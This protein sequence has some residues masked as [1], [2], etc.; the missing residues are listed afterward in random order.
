MTTSERNGDGTGADPDVRDLRGSRVLVLGAGVSGPGAVRILAALGAGVTVADSRP[1]ALDRLRAAVAEGAGPEST[2]V[3]GC[4]LDAALDAVRHGTVDLVVTSP[5]WRPDSPVPATAAAAG[6]PVWGDVELAWRADRSGLFGAPRTWL[7]ITGTNGKTTTT[8]MLEAICLEA[9]MAA[10]ACGNIGLPV[11][12]VLTAEPRVDVLACELSSFQLHWAPSCAPDVGAVLNVA[13]DHL[14]WHGSMDAYADAK[15]RALTGPVA[16][17]GV[18]DPVAGRL[19][20]ASPAAT[21]IGFRLGEP[22]PGELGVSEGWLVSRLGD[23]DTAGE[24]VRLLAAED[25]R[26]LGPAGILDALA[27]AAVA[28]S[29]GARPE[30]VGTAL[31]GFSVGAHRAA[32]VGEIDGVRY[33]DDSKATNPHAA[34]TSLLAG[35]RMVWLAGGL[36]KGADVD[37]LVAEVAGVLRGVVLVGRDRGRIAAAL[38]RHAPSVPVVDLPSGDDG[39]HAADDE[40]QRTMDRAVAEAAAL[41]APGDTVLLAPAAASMDMFT[42][43]GHR[44]RSFAEAVDRRAGRKTP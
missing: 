16:V 35:G 23:G 8:S 27:A 30:D 7:A 20:D 26:P 11:T 36:L 41:A 44:G 34:R 40:P 15:A 2:G 24:A 5:G 32:E 38:A 14:D 43:Y 28:L 19:L 6:V 3:A 31:R 39:A 10:R 4:D 18:D 25:V 22:A 29:A 13:E 17:G 9:G 37:P 33:V 42:D 1:E 12:D 21:R